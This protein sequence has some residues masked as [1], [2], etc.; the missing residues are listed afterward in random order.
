MI[1]QVRF[2]RSVWSPVA[3]VCR[4]EVQEQARQKEQEVQEQEVLKEQE[5]VVPLA[6]KALRC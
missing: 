6:V 4:I 2:P 5:A 3:T 1:L